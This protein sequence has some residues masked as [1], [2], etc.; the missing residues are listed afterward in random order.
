MGQTS[1]KLGR[2][3][4]YK[5]EKKLPKKVN[6]PRAT[7]LGQDALEMIDIQVFGD[8]SLLGTC[9]VAYIVIRQSSGTKQG[10]IETKSRHPKKQLEIPRLESVVAQMVANLADN[11]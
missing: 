2:E 7:H 4:R 5:W 11:I 1:V 3:K 10:S 9:A 6:I 8:E